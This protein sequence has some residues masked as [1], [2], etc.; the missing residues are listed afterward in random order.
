MRIFGRDIGEGEGRGEM[1]AKTDL[2]LGILQSQEAERWPKQETCNAVA[3]RWAYPC[4]HIQELDE[5]AYATLIPCHFKDPYIF[6][7][8]ER[9]KTDTPGHVLLALLPDLD[10]EQDERM[11]PS[12]PIL[13]DTVIE[14]VRLPGVGEEDEGDGL[15]KVV[16]LKAAGAHSVHDGG[17]VDDGGRNGELTRAEEEVG[18]GCSAVKEID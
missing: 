2:L 11:H 9:R 6:K 15:A 3:R 1:E 5:S 14:G 13:L 8:G 12:L 7:Q 10:I 17:I 18:V 16:E 4:C